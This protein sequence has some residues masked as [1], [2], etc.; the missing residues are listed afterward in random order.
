LLV[1]VGA[2]ERAAA[3]RYDAVSA[4][5]DRQ[6]HRGASVALAALAQTKRQRLA[7]IKKL[8]VLADGAGATKL[9]APPSASLSPHSETK[10]GWLAS[11]TPYRILRE[12][13]ETE[14][15]VFQLFVELAAYARGEPMR[16]A[17]KGLAEEQLEQLARLRVERRRAWHEERAAGD[18]LSQSIYTV[19]TLKALLDRALAIE[20]AATAELSALAEALPAGGATSD[21]L[22]KARQAEQAVRD[23]LALCVERLRAPILSGASTPQ[24][25]A[26]S[27][28]RDF[29]RALLSALANAER[30]VD[31]YLAV[32][33]RSLDENM[34]AT[35]QWLA[36]RATQRLRLLAQAHDRALLH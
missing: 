1:E 16:A 14:K 7:T 31:F 29:D 15:R 13:I 30:A 21:A 35:A 11:I 5:L 3:A 2:A 8:T 25:S 4:R 18:S 10:P 23:E 28:P 22:R 17:A 27:A 32:A 36:E 12:V 24:Q 34:L 33:E 20:A 26:N 19:T 9:A 6:G